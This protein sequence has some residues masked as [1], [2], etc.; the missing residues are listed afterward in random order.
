MFTTWYTDLAE[1]YRVVPVTSGNVTTQERTLIRADVP[2][3]VY[4]SQINNIDLRQGAATARG[5]DKLA[6]RVDTDIRAGDELLITRGGAIGS[7]QMTE[8]YIASRPQ[9]FRDP[10]GG[11]LTGLEHMEVGLTFDNI[12]TAQEPPEEA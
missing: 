6:C 11:A 8:R 9:I 4:S 7:P 2:C 3:R 1:I 10:V 5:S 12:I